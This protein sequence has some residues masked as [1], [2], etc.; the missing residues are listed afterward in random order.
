MNAPPEPTLDEDLAALRAGRTSAACSRIVERHGPLVKSACLRVLRDEGLA[1][2][3]AQETFLLLMKKA[4]HLPPTTPLAGWLYHAACRTAQNLLRTTARRR[5]REHS[6]DAITHMTPDTQPQLWA[7]LEPHLDDA[8]LSLPERQ[9]GLVLQCYFQNQSQRSAAAAHGCSES[10][11]SRELSAAMEA[12]RKFFAKKRINISAVLLVGL[13]STHGASA[14]MTGAS[15]VVASMMAASTSL[16]L[17]AALIQSKLLMGT[18]AVLGTAGLAAVGYHFASPS[19]TQTAGM[20]TTA[21]AQSNDAPAGSGSQTTASAAAWKGKW[22][23][24]FQ[25]T[26]GMALEERK[27]QVLLEAD[28]DAR[29]ALLQKLGIRLSRAAFDALIAKGLDGSVAPW[30]NTMDVLANRTEPFDHYLMAWSNEDPMAVLQWVTAQPDGG[31]GMRKQLLYALEAGQITA[32]TLR[33]WISTLKGPRQLEAAQALQAMSDP[34]SLIPKLG[35]GGNDGYLVDLAMLYGDD[36]DWTAFGLK[37]AQGKGQ[38]VARAMRQMLE[39][40]LTAEQRGLFMQALGQSTDPNISRGAVAILRAAHGDRSLDYV[41][42]LKLAAE[43]DRAGMSDFR[44]AIYEGWA[45][46][47]PTAALQYA[48]RLQDLAWMRDVIRGLP[49][50]PDE[51]TLLSWMKGTP[52]KAQDIAV[53]ALYGRS[54]AD[55]F[56]QLQRIMESTSIVDQV[57]AAQEVMRMVPLSEAAALA[58]WVKKLPPGEDRRYL[59]TALVHRLAAVDP[60]QALS[61]LQTEQLTIRDREKVV[62]NAVTQFTAKNDL[63]KS[64]EFIRQINDPKL[65]A[66]ALGQVAMVKYPGRVKEAFQFLQINSRGDW[67]PA[68]L[69]MLTDVYYNKLGNIDANAAEVLK[70]NLPKLGGEVPKRASVL[71]KLWLDQQ[72]PVSVPMAWTQQLPPATGRATRLQ[73]AQT[74]DL[75]LTAAKRYHEWAQ[76]AALDATERAQLLKH[77]EKR[78]ARP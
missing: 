1:E 62:S 76:T 36:L 64:T 12:L 27:K 67:Q 2:D 11:V 17:M 46:A 31:L 57:D 71:C 33:E 66:D 8:M 39:G 59:A 48:A 70:L 21:S 29:Y 42:T 23:A 15:A 45:K 44:I 14:S 68:A 74:Q 50:L 55:P 4:P 19:P 3:A 73:L 13:L 77:L 52:T 65:Y 9:R 16:T 7:E 75:S 53:A 72:A 30:R 56:A 35:T 60:Q 6:P 41:E 54:N 34:S 22:E 24:S 18:V 40:E 69:R 37:L 26:D 32:D 5:A 63:A 47:D 25:F 28:P 38:F 58:E 61:L 49:T 43:C 78:I 10:V 51:A 20:T